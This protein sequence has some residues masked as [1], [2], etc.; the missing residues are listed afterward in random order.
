MQGMFPETAL[1]PQT[2]PS[3]S[4]C[5]RPNFESPETVLIT[6]C[7]VV[8]SCQVSTSISFLSRH[9]CSPYKS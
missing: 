7:K 2:P 9:T 8:G 5:E 1:G 4:L 3:R 6:P